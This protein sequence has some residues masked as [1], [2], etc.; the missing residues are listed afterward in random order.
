MAARSAAE[1]VFREIDR[2]NGHAA[3]VAALGAADGAM[4]WEAANSMGVTLRVTRYGV[5]ALRVT[6]RYALRSRYGVTGRYAGAS[7]AAKEGR[8]KRC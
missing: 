3:G 6:L 2:R 5:T 4:S 1:R 7:R 8:G